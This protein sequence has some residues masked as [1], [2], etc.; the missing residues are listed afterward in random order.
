MDLYHAPLQFIATFGYAMP[1]I[2]GIF[3]I[4]PLLSREALPGMLRLSLIHI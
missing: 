2:L 1:R 3:S 4:L